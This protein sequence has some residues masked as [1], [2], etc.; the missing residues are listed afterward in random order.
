[1]INNAV[2][3]NDYG[4]VDG[5]ASRIAL[6]TAIGLAARGVK[7]YFFCAVPPVSGELQKDSIEIICLEQKD[8]LH[9]ESKLRGFRQGIYN[10][11]AAEELEKLLC[12]LSPCDTAIHIHTWTKALSASVFHI[13]EKAG[14][15]TFVTVHDYF[16]VCPNGGL[17]DYRK[18]SICELKP[19]SLKCKTCNCDSRNYA[20]KLFRVMRQLRQN[21]IIRKSGKLHY[22]FISEFS[23]KQFIRRFGEISENKKYFLP[24]PMSRDPERKRV[25]CEKNDVYLFIGGIT[26]VKGIRIFCEAV[27]KTNV[28]AVV[29]G[30]GML[31]EELQS[32]YPHI[33]FVG[34]KTKSEMLPYFERA[35]CLIFPSIWYEASP[36]TPKEVMEYGIPVICSDL[37]A[38]K[39]FVKDGETGYVYDGTSVDALAETIRLVALSDITS[40]SEKVFKEAGYYMDEDEYTDELLKIYAHTCGGAAESGETEKE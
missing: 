11:K 20:Y 9:C 7:V 30:D 23:R 31:K 18:K 25:E 4:Y 26:E 15:S 2:I 14:F 22:I 6:Q 37:N 17:F 40:V 3:I 19:M 28:K 10:K 8:S 34:W 39:D 12:G 5:G 13:S 33:D 21:K 32:R 27:E 24:N 16:L 35:R 29:I 36:L 38:A 1:M